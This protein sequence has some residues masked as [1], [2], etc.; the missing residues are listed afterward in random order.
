MRAAVYG[1]TFDPIHYGHLRVAEEVRE[2]FALDS[3]IFVPTYVNPFKEDEVTSPPEV[4]IELVRLAIEGNQGF[5]VSDIETR[6]PETSYTI[7]TVKTL[8][9]ERGEGF[10]LSLIVGTDSFN[11]IRMWC[12][13]EELFEHASFIVVPRPGHEPK[14]P[15]EAL[16][17]ELARKFWYDSE[18]ECYRNSF[19]TTITYVD[20]TLLDISSTD[21][22]R[23]VAEG[24]SIRYLVPRNVE[25]YITEHGLY[26]EY[27]S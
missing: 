11:D 22:R 1:G 16:P 24:R 7:N 21:I 12:A 15:G 25:R 27:G 13:Y 9:E 8:K 10:E 18:G 23:R 4:R 2:G 26:R 14:K 5:V 17:V 19:G 6:R 20:T 3:I